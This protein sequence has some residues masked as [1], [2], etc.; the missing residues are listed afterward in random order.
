MCVIS[1]GHHA[2]VLRWFV[3]QVLFCIPVIRAL[4]LRPQSLCYAHSSLH[5]E[6]I[7]PIFFLSL[8]DSIL[9]CLCHGNFSFLYQSRLILLLDKLFQIGCHRLLGLELS[10]ALLTFQVSVE[11]LAAILTSFSLYVTCIV[12]S[13]SFSML[14][15][16]YFML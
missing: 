6:I 13:C 1:C 12:L 2:T 4:C 14:Y 15:Y 5:S 10:Q 3:F 7:L 8:L 9:G 16:V 11:K